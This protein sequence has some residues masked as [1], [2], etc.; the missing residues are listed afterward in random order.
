M[1]KTKRSRESRNMGNKIVETCSEMRALRRT[2]VY[3][4]ELRTSHEHR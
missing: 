1:T 4:L 3:G 2:N